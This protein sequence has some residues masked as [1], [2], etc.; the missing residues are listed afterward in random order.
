MELSSDNDFFSCKADK[1]EEKEK[2]VPQLNI[3]VFFTFYQT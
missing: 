2:F 1:L 3:N